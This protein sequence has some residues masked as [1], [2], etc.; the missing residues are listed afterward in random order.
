MRTSTK[1]APNKTEPQ[2]WV[3]R[4]VLVIGAVCSGG[5]LVM[6]IE[7]ERQGKVNYKISS[8]AVW[9][10]GDTLPTPDFIGC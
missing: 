4:Y 2:S 9:A 5:Q 3:L 8:L 10:D 7:E 6:Q 1:V